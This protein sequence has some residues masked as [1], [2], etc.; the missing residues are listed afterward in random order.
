MRTMLRSTTRLSA[1]LAMLAT[2]GCDSP[3]NPLD[4]QEA[5][6]QAM[7][8]Q[9][10]DKLGTIEERIDSLE[11]T[12]TG[13]GGAGLVLTGLPA[14]QLDSVLALASYLA[15][16]A[17]S[18]SWEACGGAELNGE[19]GI[20]WKGTAEGEGKGSLGAW[21]GTG[22]YAGADVKVSQ[23]VGGGFK[24]GGKGGVEFCYPLGAGSPPVRPTPAGPMRAPELDQLRT[25]LDGLT[26]QFNLTPATLAA[27]LS[28]VSTVISSPG[29]LSLA[30]VG[31]MLPLPPAVASIASNPVGTVTSQISNIAGQAQSALCSGSGWGSNMSAVITQACSVINSGG[32]ANFTVLADIANTYPAVEAA[33]STVCTRVNS[34]G[35]QRLIIPSWDVTIVNTTYEVFPGYNQRLF[36]SYTSVACP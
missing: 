23:E 34:I 15:E 20:D 24:I 22:A 14:A 16:D 18:G 6:T 36:P 33:I 30:G 9:I 5:S 12:M 32:M 29:S 7:L 28:G 1:F 27:S 17:S 19:F 2:A 31:T 3:V 26:T 4:A 11:A 25:T 8:A 35:L 13:T 10:L 21:A